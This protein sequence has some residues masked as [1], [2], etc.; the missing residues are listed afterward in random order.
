[1]HDLKGLLGEVADQTTF[2]VAG[3]RLS[4]SQFRELLQHQSPNDE[5]AEDARNAQAILPDDL[6]TRLFSNTR[7]NFEEYVERSTDR[8]GHAFPV[9]GGGPP[10][11]ASE[12]QTTYE[13]DGVVSFEETSPVETFAKALA[14]GAAVLG[15]DRATR[16]ALGWARGE[17]VPYKTRSVL[18]IDGILPEPPLPIP[19][20]RIESLPLSTDRLTS[21]LPLFGNQ[22]LTQYLGRMILTIDHSAAPALFRPCTE[23]S[24]RGRRA[25]GVPDVTANVICQALALETDAFTEVAFS[26][27]DFG[28][29]D[30]F[31]LGGREGVW[32]TSRAYFRTTSYSNCTVSTDHATGVT[33]L[34][35]NDPTE[36]RVDGEQLAATLT[37]L[38]EPTP[39]SLRVTASRW[40]RSKDASSG[41]EDQFVDLRIA[42]ESLYLHDFDNEHS[43]EMGFRLA[44]F[45]A[46]HLGAGFQERKVV[47]KTL[48]DA[49]KKASGVVHTGNIDSACEKRKL[50]NTGLRWL[51]NQKLLSDAQNIV[52]RGLLAMLRE[53]PPHNWGDLVLGDDTADTE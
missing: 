53:G 2:V 11:P 3:S 18:N 24:V 8:I 14:R 28:D 43:Q 1:M 51:E 52:R 21:Y 44:L 33:T 9:R 17:P 38:E 37:A 4:G 12:G 42:L 5:E 7:E 19:G 50:K 15:A 23:K 49:Y 36:L 46:W 35:F 39:D 10:W 32:S 20:V 16:L 13:F 6:L 31:R 25:R 26:W 48:R 22:S 34:A 40:L 27:N 47:R 45:G 30:A 41:L 29:L